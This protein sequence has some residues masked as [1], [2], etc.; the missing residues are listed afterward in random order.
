MLHKNR[1]EHDAVC[2]RR[3][4]ATWTLATSG[5]VERF[6][7]WCRV[8]CMGGGVGFGRGGGAKTSQG[9]TCARTW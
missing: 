4:V 5:G 8:I 3:Q 6:A 1:L 9:E 2:P 7:W